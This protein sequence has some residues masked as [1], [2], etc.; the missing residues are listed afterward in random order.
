[1][2]SLQSRHLFKL[3]LRY[4]VQFKRFAVV[5]VYLPAKI[6]RAGPL[7]GAAAEPK[8]LSGTLSG[9]TPQT[10]SCSVG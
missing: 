5:G 2:L 9:N 3:L 6:R 1:L 10:G 8:A 4:W 7:V